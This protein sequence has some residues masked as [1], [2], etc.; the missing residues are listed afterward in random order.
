MKNILLIVL[1]F[2]SAT[3]NAQ[4]KFLEAYINTALENN[5]G[6][7]S[8]V[9]HIQ[10]VAFEKEVIKG[11]S[12]SNLD[13]MYG[14]A[15]APIETKNGPINHKMSAGVMLPW[16]GSRNA[17]YEVVDYRVEKAEKEKEQ[18]ENT[19]KFS[20]RSLYFQML[21]NQKDLVSARSNSSIL[22]TFES[23]ALTQYENAKT[24]LV[25]VL[26]VQMQ[27]DDASNKITSLV[28]DSILLHHQFELVLNQKMEE[29]TLEDQLLFS[30]N[31]EG[32][33]DQNPL[34]LS[35]NA[36]Q[37]ELNSEIIAVSK[38]ASPQI[39]IAL[40]YSILGDDGM[41]GDNSGRNAVMPMVGLSIPVFNSKKYSGKKEQ[42]A[43][44]NQSI[45]FQKKELQNVLTSEYLKAQN[46]K[47]DAVRD[48][49]VIGL[50]IS[51]VDQAIK[52]QRE[53]YTV[54]D[55]Q[56]AAFIELLR[57]QIQKLDYEFKTHEAEQNKW[58][59][60]AKIEFIMGL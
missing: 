60:M 7:Q 17:K 48:M 53:T 15:A 55:T 14:Y 2:S 8:K 5:F 40:E 57:L 52:I 16:F 1:I 39:K 58:D 38:A 51:K 23:I 56:G 35:L 3:I 47:E 32:V 46:Q 37:S 21:Q 10:A 25:D 59:A 22:T 28:K 34:L 26:R 12:T 50:Q 29:V 20:V 36:T 31:N 6:V 11:E 19:V 4:N 41:S 42:L 24:S 44:N 18:T 45:S 43:L 54:G 33:I 9:Q 13:L 27:I 30:T 49:D